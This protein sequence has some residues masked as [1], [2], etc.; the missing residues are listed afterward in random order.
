MAQQRMLMKGS[1][2][3]A[4]AAIRAGCR[5]FFGYPI[6][7]QNEI[8]EYMAKRLPALG[9][10]YLQAES[11]VAAINMLYGAGGTGARV[12]TSSS[13]PGIALMSEGASYMV[14]SE[15]P[16]VIVD[17]MRGGPGLGGI[18]PAQSDWSMVTRGLGHGDK[19]YLVLA[20]STVQE[21]VDLIALAFQKADEY[22]NPV[23]MIGDG[24]I[25]QMM[26]PVTFPDAPV[27][28]VDKPWAATGK[29]PTRKANL[30]RSLRLDPEELE[31]HVKHLF[32]KFA[33]MEEREQRH[34][35]FQLDDRPPLVLVAYGTTA[36][37]CT[38]AVLELRRHGIAVGLFRPITAWPFPQEALRALVESTQQFLCIEM[39]M[40]QMT[41]D[42]RGLIGGA[43]PVRSYF[44][45]GGMVPTVE[46]IVEQAR[47][48]VA[49]R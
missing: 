7:P 37:I 28:L 2:A 4:E 36:R 33:R 19:R 14:G 24:L 11:E 35:T 27:A 38:S 42:V 46:E 21:A 43:R 1:E 3:I 44:R 8:P 12:M 5:Y 15:L 20:P 41:D 25:G 40:G 39:S 47:Q 13:S 26:E 30:V 6:T 16:A 31:R 23:V 32:E 48:A 34:A 22:R 45:T 49:A 29:P 10:T 17:I 18:S 9:G